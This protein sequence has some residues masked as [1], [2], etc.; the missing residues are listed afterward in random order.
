MFTPR[1]NQHRAP[2]GAKRVWVPACSLWVSAQGRESECPCCSRGNRVC[3][4]KPPLASGPHDSGQGW[5]RVRAACCSQSRSLRT[6][7]GESKGRSHLRQG[8]PSLLRQTPASLSSETQRGGHAAQGRKE[9]G[10][11]Q[12]KW[13]RGFGSGNFQQENILGNRPVGQQEASPVACF[14]ELASL[15]L[16]LWWSS[17]SVVSDSFVTPWTAAHQAPLSM[18]FSRQEQWS[19]LPFP[20]PGDLPDPGIRPSSLALAG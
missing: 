13:P 20:S 16:Q 15:A 5:E 1:G 7:R 2:S 18:G 4:T 19:G 10:T 12:S 17:H 9:A 6:G 8:L 11:R 3:V 14:A